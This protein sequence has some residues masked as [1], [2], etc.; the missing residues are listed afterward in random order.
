MREGPVHSLNIPSKVGGHGLA[1]RPPAGIPWC[2]P[3]R[4]K[5]GQPNQ[6]RSTA[7]TFPRSP[8]AYRNSRTLA[9]NELSKRSPG[10]TTGSRRG[11]RSPSRSL[12]FAATLG[13]SS[14]KLSRRRRGASS[15]PAPFVEN[16]L[17][18]PFPVERPGIREFSTGARLSGPLHG[19]RCSGGGRRHRLPLS[20][21]RGSSRPP[22]AS[23][24][25]GS[26]HGSPPRLS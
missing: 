5:K 14:R 10:E 20:H 6:T 8:P 21:R 23:P 12:P 1:R 15:T 17:G 18:W 3:C 19:R 24:G 16:R 11:T 26:S 4:R 7:A 22:V 13:W 2:P 25:R 9:S